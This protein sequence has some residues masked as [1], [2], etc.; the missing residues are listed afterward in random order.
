MRVEGGR[1]CVLRPRIHRAANECA[2]LSTVMACG[3]DRCCNT[4]PSVAATLKQPGKG[5]SNEEIIHA[6]H[7]VEGRVRDLYTER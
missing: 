3:A 7:Q 6:L 5:R 4:R 2:A 1:R